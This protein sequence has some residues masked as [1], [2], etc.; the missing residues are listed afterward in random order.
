LRPHPASAV[1]GDRHAFDVDVHP[2]WSIGGK[3]NGGYLLSLLGRA[4]LAAS[5]HP[6]VLAASAHY[7]KPPEFGAAVAEVETLRAGRSATQLRARLVQDGTSR[8]EAL[9]TTGQV[10]TSA[11]PYWDGGV[12]DPAIPDGWGAAGGVG[13]VRG[14]RVPARTPTGMPVPIMDQVD[15]RLDPETFGFGVG[16]PSG[17][18]ELRGW[19]AAPDGARFDTAALLF[20]LDA[21]P[22]ATFD[23]E[24]SGWVPTLELT[25]YVRALPVPGPLRVLQRAHLIAD[26]RVDESCWVWDSH[27]RV[28]AHGSQLAGIRL[29]SARPD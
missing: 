1:G 16:R 3:P 18:G 6:H 19:L 28:V 27:G 29:G 21:L 17:R 24:L 8:V 9:L 12:P 22:P 23:V 11:P 2:D 4:A 13:G 7:L 25:A 26:A 15:L 20:A 10:D 14:V 5:A